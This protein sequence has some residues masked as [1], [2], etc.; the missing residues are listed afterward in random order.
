MAIET[1]FGCYNKETGQVDF[2]QNGASP[3]PDDERKCLYVGCYVTHADDEVHSGQI[4][5]DVFSVTCVSDTYYA[6]FDPVTGQFEIEVEANCCG[7][8]IVCETVTPNTWISS[9]SVTVCE[10]ASCIGGGNGEYRNETGHGGIG[11]EYTRT[12]SCRWD[13]PTQGYSWTEAFPVETGCCISNQENHAC[14][15]CSA[16][17]TTCVEQPLQGCT[18]TVSTGSCSGQ[19]RIVFQTNRWRIAGPCGIGAQSEMIGSPNDCCLPIFLSGGGCGS[20]Q[21]SRYTT[22]GNIRGRC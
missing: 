17:E 19:S 7:Y 11:G 13:G 1:V 3:D 12:S 9:V 10:D 8:C 16:S 20:P 22:A 5:V 18:C 21:F 2:V 14:K 15:N 4:Q 6:C